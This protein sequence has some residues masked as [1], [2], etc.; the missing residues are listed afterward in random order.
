MPPVIARYHDQVIRKYYFR[1]QSYNEVN[2]TLDAIDQRQQIGI[3]GQGWAVPYNIQFQLTILSDSQIGICTRLEKQN[4]YTDCL[5]ADAQTFE[6]IAISQNLQMKLLGEDTSTIKKKIK[7]NRIIVDIEQFLIKLNQ[8]Q[9]FFLVIQIN[10]LKTNLKDKLEQGTL[11]TVLSRP[12]YKSLIKQDHLNSVSQRDL[13]YDYDDLQKYQLKADC[14]Y[15]KS[16]FKRIIQLR[17]ISLKPLS[18]SEEICQIIQKQRLS[19][20]NDE[21]SIFVQ[22]INIT[23]HSIFSQHTK[24]FIKQTQTYVSKYAKVEPQLDEIS[25]LYSKRIQSY[26]T[27]IGLNAKFSNQESFTN[28]ESFVNQESFFNSERIFLQNNSTRK[29]RETNQ[30]SFMNQENTANTERILTKNQ[31]KQRQEEIN[32]VLYNV[33]FEQEGTEEK[34]NISEQEDNKNNIQIYQS[35]ARSRNTDMT[36]NKF[37]IMARN[38][39]SKNQILG[40]KLINLFGYVFFIIIITLSLVNYYILNNAYIEQQNEVLNLD[41]PQ[42]VQNSLQQEVVDLYFQRLT[43]DKYILNNLFQQNEKKILV[44]RLQAQMKNQ[45]K[46]LKNYILKHLLITYPSQAVENLILSERIY[47]QFETQINQYVTIDSSSIYRIEHI[48]YFMLESI[49]I[50]QTFNKQLLGRNDALIIDNFEKI[51]LSYINIK[52]NMEEAIQEKFNSLLSHAEQTF[53]SVLSFSII[54]FI[55]F[56][57]IYSYVQFKRNRILVGVS[58]FT[59]VQ[60]LNMI[61]Q[62]KKNQQTIEEI[63]NMSKNIGELRQIKKQLD[64]FKSIQVNQKKQLEVSEQKHLRRSKNILKLKRFS[65]IL[66]LIC[67]VII[68]LVQI[69]SFSI[70]VMVKS[71]LKLLAEER[72]FLDVMSNVQVMM[73]RS[74]QYTPQLLLLKMYYPQEFQYYYNQYK[75][76]IAQNIQLN[77]QHYD[78]YLKQ[79]NVNRNNQTLFMYYIDGLYK[80]DACNMT[81][82]FASYVTGGGFNL[83]DCNLVI[84]QVFSQGIIQGITFFYEYLEQQFDLIALQ[85]LTKFMSLEKNLIKE[86]TFYQQNQ[87]RLNLQQIFSASKKFVRYQIMGDYANMIN[88]NYFYFILQMSVSCT[89]FI[90]TWIAFF[91]HLKRQYLI[92]KQSLDVFD[93]HSLAN[94]Q[95]IY[96]QFYQIK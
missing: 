32:K 60:L 54:F 10:F 44:P 27:D 75:S 72:Q 5:I 40:L 93:L 18:N 33:T 19:K 71:F 20:I 85:D 29:L 36:Y 7:L 28:Q 42:Q 81:Q 34:H 58:L 14:I 57:V 63:M 65:L 77:Q 9:I 50:I 69:Y 94:N 56:I 12:S 61:D 31:N 24:P 37:K 30:E 1:S 51:Q 88:G 52:Y 21:K 67:L 87:F 47:Y 6:I 74:A 83:T 90:F 82:Q 3:D 46:L 96:N 38:I 64:A 45:L 62:N 16:T 23:G 43:D 78:I 70:F 55:F 59:Q 2:K 15:K 80:S 92:S 53:Y 86:F 68:S 91:S 76:E 8:S 39:H 26:Q 35:E 49:F 95:R 25:P 22:D 84:N 11:E 66:S 89:L 13:F 41:W 73:N 4:Q 79:Q 48:V 17:V